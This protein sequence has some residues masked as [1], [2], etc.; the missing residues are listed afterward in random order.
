MP[1]VP[2]YVPVPVECPKETN[3][4]RSSRGSE[5]LA[6]LPH[7]CIQFLLRRRAV[8]DAPTTTMV[9][10]VVERTE[11]RR[12]QFHYHD[13]EDN[14][15][16]QDTKLNQRE[17][18]GEYA[19]KSLR[20]FASNCC[21]SSRRQCHSH[22]PFFA[23]SPYETTAI[24]YRHLIGYLQE[25]TSLIAEL[26]SILVKMEPRHNS[27]MTATTTTTT[28]SV[29]YFLRDLQ[30]K[31]KQ[32]IQSQ[33][34]MIPVVLG[35]TQT[36]STPLPFASSSSSPARVSYEIED[37]QDRKTSARS[38]STH[39]GGPSSSSSSHQLVD[40]TS[41]K[42]RAT[43]YY[44]TNI[45]I[46]QRGTASTAKRGGSTKAATTAD[47]PSNSGHRLVHFGDHLLGGGGG[48]EPSESLL[49]T[50]NDDDDDEEGSSLP[51]TVI[52]SHRKRMTIVQE[53]SNPLPKLAIAATMSSPTQP[54]SR[55]KTICPPTQ[56]RLSDFDSSMSVISE[57]GTSPVHAYHRH[58][59]PYEE[60]EEEPMAA[61]VAID[62]EEEESSHNNNNNM[63]DDSWSTETP[64]FDRFRVDYDPTNP[65]QVIVRPNPRQSRRGKLAERQIM[66]QQ[67]P[68]Q[69]TIDENAPLDLSSQQKPS[70][71]PADQPRTSGLR[72]VF[73]AKETVSPG[74][75]TVTPSSRNSFAVAHNETTDQEETQRAFL[76]SG[77]D[78]AGEFS[79]AARNVPARSLSTRSSQRRPPL[80]AIGRR[81]HRPSHRARSFKSLPSSLLLYAEAQLLANAI[82]QILPI[83]REE[84]NAAPRIV[85]LQVSLDLLEA[86]I[87][88]LNR[89]IE[90]SVADRPIQVKRMHICENDLLLMCRDLLLL[91]DEDESQNCK[92]VLSALCYFQRLWLRTPLVPGE[93]AVFDL[94]FD[95]TGSGQD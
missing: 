92:N 88:I 24:K 13:K 22:S 62:K 77:I 43:G 18:I 35:E 58:R 36:P 91:L 21:K 51:P 6:P 17:D 71:R 31:N 60:P 85:H 78:E 57:I 46:A 14:M 11:D 41:P 64:F 53:P 23:S 19:V 55:K 63:E 42:Y 80:T 67:R 61:A 72:D 45:S 25:Q 56:V 52:A 75:Q 73:R 94:I 84:Y 82:P 30:I 5:G 7:S 8:D 44:E 69:A 12:S 95:E 38:R 49:L 20:C 65:R 48:G 1:V 81:D 70:P 29:I 76:D 40:E 15:M 86:V 28:Q 93:L 3:D 54:R 87:D 79:T 66:A 4:D 39:K 47:P 50:S 68:L 33:N 89:K 34:I 16:F 26:E 9:L 37:F 90:D 59:P 27:P 83:G 74:K 32:M 10:A 2:T